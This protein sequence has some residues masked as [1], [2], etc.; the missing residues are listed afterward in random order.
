MSK[1]NEEEISYEEAFGKL[2]EIVSRLEE[3][4]PDLD[5]LVRDYEEGMAL[6]KTCHERLN[7]AALRIEKVADDEKM[8]L[9]PFERTSS[10][11]EAS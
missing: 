1:K 2:Q 5:H 10:P 9:E 8:S 4:E 3:D 7:E 11:T 6:L